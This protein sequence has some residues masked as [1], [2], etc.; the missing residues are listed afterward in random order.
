[1]PDAV[2]Q[3]EMLAPHIGLVTLNRPEKRNA[4]N[5]E[6]AQALEAIVEQTEGDPEVRA[7]IITSSNDRV[8]CAGADLGAVSGGVGELLETAHGGFAGFVYAQRHKPWIAAVEGIAV[9]GG[10]E[11]CLAC[12]MIVASVDAR[13]GLP[14]V[15]RG[16]MA[17]AG[18][19]HRLPNRI[20]PAIA[21]ELI[22]SGE[23][24]DAERAHMHGLINRLVSQGETVTQARELAEQ[25]IVN[26]PLAVQYSLAAARSTA[27]LPDGAGRPL[28]NEWLSHLRKTEDFRE[29]P[30]A[31]IEKREPVWTGR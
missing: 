23:Q 22:A 10:F 8:F 11:I 5:G 29:G 19:L 16:L 24:M 1:M 31:F 27:S 30:R 28:V 13:F 14:E 6:M 17:G 4:I 12:D 9:A 7:V 25:I 3:F 21:F 26:A 2:I 18:G 15:K 20:P